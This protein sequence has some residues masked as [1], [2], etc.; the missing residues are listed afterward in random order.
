MSFILEQEAKSV[1]S[2]LLLI[3]LI[4]SFLTGCGSAY[5]PPDIFTENDINT[6]ETSICANM[7]GYNPFTLVQRSFIGNPTA[8]INPYKFKINGEL[9]LYAVALGP[10]TTACTRKKSSKDASVTGELGNREIARNELIGTAI[11]LADAAI[12]THLGSIKSTETNMNLFFGAATAGLTGGASVAGTEAGAK[13]LSAAATGTNAGRSI[14]NET[15]Y[16]NAL[17]ETLTGSIE[18]D[19]DVK[20]S[21]LIDRLTSECVSSYPVG[22]ALAD[23]QKYLAGG[24]FY[25]GLALIR[26]AAE[27]ANSKR[28]GKD[29]LL[30]DPITKQI[31]E[32]K[33]LELKDQA[34]DIQNKIDSKNNADSTK[35]TTQ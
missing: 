3:L 26:E 2:N 24:S 4:S 35:S 14:F 28:R 16:R 21:E 5:R 32:N 19:R 17:G 10:I 1:K 20:R 11:R 7:C 30:E 12:S 27:Q 15:T 29:I 9:S 18:T 22:I 34:A 8:Q 6:I 13:V 25:H 23:V 33:L 31:Y